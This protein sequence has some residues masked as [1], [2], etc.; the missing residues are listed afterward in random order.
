MTLSGPGYRTLR[1]VVAWTIGVMLAGG[2]VNARADGAASDSTER[3][4][5]GFVAA[6]F[7]KYAPETGWAFG[8]VGFYYFHLVGD[9]AHESGPDR[10]S[11]ISGGATYTQ[12]H[13]ISTGID[14]DFYFVGETYHLE[15]G[16]D[17]KRIPVDFYG[18]GD[19]NGVDPID[20]YTPLWIGGDAEFTTN[21]L[22]TE[23]GEGVNAG[24]GAEVRHDRILSSDPGG[25]L[26]TGS[27]QGSK[28]G[29]S[30]GVGIVL[31]YDTRDNVFSTHN[32]L[33]AGLRTLSYGRLTGSD[34]SFSRLT[35]DLRQFISLFDTHTAAFQEL[36]L[37][38]SGTEPFYTMARLGGDSNLRGYFEGRFRNNDMAV[39]QAEYRLPLVWRFGLAAFA[40]F[41]EV[42]G[43]LREYKLT[44]L[45]FSGG[46][47]IR[48]TVVPEERLG[49]RLDY[50]VG[51]D[52]SEVY[53][54]ILEAF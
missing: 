49:V 10:P 51:S 18:V 17:Y 22:R 14:Y 39:V 15:G 26:E 34:F 47:G 3:P 44:G 37:F 53:F 54:S 9:S 23:V 40:D 42:A 32:G 7:L 12:K 48:F 6:P 38:V 27:V 1:A 52:S 36:F 25:I 21:L 29:L 13:Q 2:C 30:S 50:G 41:G 4:R 43:A 16:F 46:A 20:S 11:R 35:L 31:D 33:Y 5:Q 45:K 8:A 19:R 24:I 28:G